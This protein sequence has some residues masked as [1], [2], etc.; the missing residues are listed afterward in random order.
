MMVWIS[1]LRV[2]QYG[3]P[4]NVV[5]CLHASCSE[6]VR[7]QRWIGSMNRFRESTCTLY[8]NLDQTDSLSHTHLRWNYKTGYLVMCEFLWLWNEDSVAHSTLRLRK[9]VA[10]FLDESVHWNRTVTCWIKRFSQL[11]RLND[12]FPFLFFQW[13]QFIQKHI[14]SLSFF[15]FFL[16]YPH[17]IVQGSRDFYSHSNN[18]HALS[19]TIQRPCGVSPRLAKC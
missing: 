9:Q 4:C 10:I 16:S 3:W 13:T 17:I 8:R 14:T 1:W 2:H 6:N 15:L 19:W 12:I 7:A 11:N 5:L 18:Q